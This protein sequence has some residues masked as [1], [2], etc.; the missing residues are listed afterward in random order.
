MSTQFSDTDKGRARKRRNKYATVT[1]LVISSVFHA[2]FF[3]KDF[4]PFDKIVPV[5]EQPTPLDWVMLFFAIYLIPIGIYYLLTPSQDLPQSSTR[6][7]AFTAFAGLA[8]LLGLIGLVIG[9]VTSFAI[10]SVIS[11]WM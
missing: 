7:E 4:H 9:A 6:F 11:G 1:A 8:I 2:L 5:G 3:M 10:T